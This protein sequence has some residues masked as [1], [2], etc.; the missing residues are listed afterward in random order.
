MRKI[1]L[2]KLLQSNIYTGSGWT[3]ADLRSAFTK[4]SRHWAEFVEIETTGG[5]QDWKFAS[6]WI[7]L[8]VKKTQ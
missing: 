1:L 2:G 6:L 8:L 4:S 7:H 3:I 5:R